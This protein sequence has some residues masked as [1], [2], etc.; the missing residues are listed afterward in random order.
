MPTPAEER[1]PTDRDWH[2]DELPATAA[3]RLPDPGDALDRGARRT[4][5]PRRR[6]R[7]RPRRVQAPHPATTCCGAP[8]PRC[9]PTRGTWRST[10]ATSTAGSRTACSPTVRAK[11]PART[12]RV[13][14]RFRTWK[15]ALRDDEPDRR[16]T[17]RSRRRDRRALPARAAVPPPAHARARAARL[18]GDAAGRSRARRRVRHRHVD[19]RARRFRGHGRRARHVAGDDARRAADRRTSPTCSGTP[20]HSRSPRRRFDAVTCSSGVHWFDQDRFFAE[21]PARGAPGRLDRAVRPLLH[22][23]AGRR[24]SSGPGSESSSRATRSRRAT[25][26]SAIRARDARRLRARRRPICS[27]TRSR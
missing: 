20:R 19:R 7:R 1:P 21:L 25:R 13:H 6:S 15:E 4:A 2:T 10:R 18:V 11:A 24:R 23:H 12:A 5:D 27:T 17:I 26:R 16:L 14:T 22:G 3:A 8:G 9:T